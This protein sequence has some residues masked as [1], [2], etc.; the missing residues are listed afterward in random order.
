M[1]RLAAVFDS[2]SAIQQAHLPEQSET[3]S[4]NIKSQFFIRYYFNF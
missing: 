3:I 4:K 1:L 2:V